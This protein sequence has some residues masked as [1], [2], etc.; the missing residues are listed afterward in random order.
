M[1]GRRGRGIPGAGGLGGRRGPIALDRSV[2]PRRV[3]RADRG[4]ARGPTASAPGVEASGSSSSV[5]LPGE[6]D[7][8]AA[9]DSARRYVRSV[10][11]IGEQVAEALEYAHQQGTL[12]R[13]IKPSNLLLDAH[14][15]V[16]VT[17]FGLAKA[18]GDDDLT[19][20]GDIVG[21][22]RYMA[23]ERFRGRCDARSDVYALGLTLYEMLAFRPAFPARRPARP[24]PPDH[25]G[26]AAPAPPPRPVDP[27][28]PGDDRAQ[29]D[30]EGPGP[31]LRAR[32]G[33]WPTTC[34][35]SSTTARSAPVE[36]PAIERL[37][38]W[39]RRNK[40]LAASLAAIGLLLV[41]LA[42][43]STTAAVWY[44][45]QNGELLWSNYV[46]LV[47]RADFE[48]SQNNIGRAEELLT[49][50]PEGLRSIE[51]HYVKR[52]CR[53]AIATLAQTDQ[54]VIDLA[55]APDGSWFVSADG[56]KFIGNADDRAT[57]AVREAK[58]GVARR[59]ISVAGSIRRVAVSPDG[60]RIAYV[61][62]FGNSESSGEGDSTG[63]VVVCDAETLETAWEEPAPRH[64]R[65]TD[66]AIHPDG[67]SV[68]VGHASSEVAEDASSGGAVLYDL[69]TGAKIRTFR[70][71]RD[72]GVTAVAFSPD[73]RTIALAG[74]EYLELRDAT[75]GESLGVL[76]PH[77]ER[78]IFA[79]AFSP[80]GK[81]LASG[82]FDRAIRLWDVRARRPL[83]EIL[84]D[85]FIQDLAFSPD[86]R[87]L[88][89]ANES[90][91]VGLVDMGSRRRVGE[92]RGH[93][94]YVLSVA[95]QPDSAHLISGGL[96]HTILLWDRIT[97]RPIVK[98]L[99][100]WVTT[101]GFDPTSGHSRIA[102]QTPSEAKRD[103]FT[104]WNPTNGSSSG[105]APAGSR[106][107]RS[108]ARLRSSL[109]RSS[110]APMAGGSPPAMA[111]ARS[112]S[113]RPRPT[114]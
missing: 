79:L 104:L 100:G 65:A 47:N 63:R 27:A 77:H 30:R 5:T 99:S 39:A 89:T 109:V 52:R 58:T 80:D 34:S 31:S 7:L 107:R 2:R 51:W 82:G 28:R 41:T 68:L 75:S 64:N 73:R 83:A 85:G 62:G 114:G 16:W 6:S 32:P 108:M 70:I 13:D 29:G 61:V 72:R 26:G 48:V 67:K 92:F 18:T 3:G 103:T 95:W 20:T 56:E 88:A 10:A 44:Q 25:A 53:L 24:D 46:N 101:Y 15:T 111:R 50:C 113:A 60:R 102:T 112:R 93:T 19:H 78:W 94:S 90:R 69:T 91:A 45:K 4:R 84:E 49:A 11:R 22:V 33:T 74:R 37:A 54:D 1:D 98:D 110:S 59:S 9:T 86:G 76:E 36:S 57:L 38:R 71:A 17:D 43:G 12:H 55:Y 23:P 66:L 42:F 97:S 105:P 96:D 106:T 35:G 81:T 21:T 8:S 87:W 40:G 14:G